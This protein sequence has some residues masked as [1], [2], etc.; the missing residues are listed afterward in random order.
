MRR[1]VTD[2]TKLPD[3]NL[4]EPHV[5]LDDCSQH[6]QKP[7]DTAADDTLMEPAGGVWSNV[8]DMMKWAKALLDAMHQE[9]SVLNETPTIVSHKSHITTSSLGE[10]TYRLGFARAMIPST[11][12]GMLSFDGPQREHIIGESSRPRLVLY[13]NGEVS[14]QRAKKEYERYARLAADFVYFRHEERNEEQ[15]N[16]NLADYVGKYVNA[17]LTMML[18]IRLG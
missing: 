4:A 3:D 11:N 9:P 18:D 1:T 10:N 7:V 6:R 5:V 14:V 2:R 8:S 17:G 15:L 13:H 16:I 12:L